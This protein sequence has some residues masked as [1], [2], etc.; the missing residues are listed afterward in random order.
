[1][2]SDGQ[3]VREEQRAQTRLALGAMLIPIFF[4]IAFAVCIIGVYHKPHPNDIKLGVVGPP[5]QT[6]P[7][8]AGLAKAGGSAFE[9][10]AVATVA[11]AT[12]DVRQRDLQAAFVPSANPQLPATSIVARAGGRLVATATESFLRS[13]AA[14]QGRQL[15]TRDV[16]PLA[17]GDPIGIGVFMFMI[18][19]TICGYLAVTLLFTV[20]PALPPSRRY[21]IIA[22]IAV[23][24]PAIAC[25]IGGLGFGT[26]TGSV[27]TI[28]A[29]IGVGAL[30]VFAIGLITRLLQVLLGPPALFVSLAIFVFLNIPS[31]G[32]T[33]TPELLPGFWRF[34]NHFWIGAETTNAERSI[35]YFGGLGVGTD[36]LRLL[37]WT[38]VIVALLLLPVSRKLARQR[39]RSVDAVPAVAAGAGA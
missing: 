4:V 20:A 11:E 1:M 32:A 21:P 25:L 8:R 17:S 7:V 15:V 14:S 36:M 29:F 23:L 9:I 2:T 38:G 10:S 34:L 27:G 22:G 28:L 13:V 16:R 6:A 26:Y 3:A 30:Y 18:V 35:L 31:L 37:A 33:Y 24:V 12:R 19:C 5:A 39:E